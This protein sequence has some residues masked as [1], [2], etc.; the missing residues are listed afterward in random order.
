MTIGESIL[1][2]ARM[3]FLMWAVNCYQFLF[4]HDL[5]F[6][7][8]IPR[9]WKGLVGIATSPFIHGNIVHLT[10]NT[11]PLLFLGTALYYFYHRIAPKVFLTAYFLTGVAVWLFARP[12]STHIGASGVIYALASFLVFY[13]IF[14]RDFQSLLISG[15][16]I[17]FYGSLIWGVLPNNPDVSWESHLS[18][19][20]VGLACAFW[21]RKEQAA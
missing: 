15:V 1:V 9:T 2:P 18:G 20:L 5:G 6:L 10:S 4:H 19:G 11:L 16:V 17:F 12:S 13:G 3:I 14:K 8:I 7:G 21:F